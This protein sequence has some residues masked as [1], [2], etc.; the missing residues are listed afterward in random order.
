MEAMAHEEIPPEFEDEPQVD[1]SRIRKAA[2]IYLK[3]L[4]EKNLDGGPKLN[5][6]KDAIGGAA[7]RAAD[8]ER[9]MWALGRGVPD[10]GYQKSKEFVHLHW[11]DIPND[12]R[13]AMTSSLLNWLREEE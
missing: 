2:V 13:K 11:E 8:E 9:R 6:L 1:F 5:V 3:D 7:W 10:L 4:E 12:V